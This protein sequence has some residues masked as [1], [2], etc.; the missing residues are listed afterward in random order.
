MRNHQQEYER[1]EFVGTCEQHVPFAAG[2]NA[3]VADRSTPN[4]LYVGTVGGGVIKT[5]DGGTS[6]TNASAGPGRELSVC[7]SPIL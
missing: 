4:T 1:R 7:L 2:I 6:W 3:M 5:T